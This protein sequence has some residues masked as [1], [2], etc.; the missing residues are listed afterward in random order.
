VNVIMGINQFAKMCGHFYDGTNGSGYN[1]KHPE[2]EEMQDDI[3]W[4]H[5]WACPFRC[6]P[7]NN[8]FKNCTRCLC[9]TCANEVNWRGGSKHTKIDCWN[10][11]AECTIDD[12][13]DAKCYTCRCPDYFEDPLIL[14]S[15]EAR[16]RKISYERKQRDK[17]IAI[18]RR[19]SFHI[20]KHERGLT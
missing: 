13:R 10:C 17:P 14:E 1:C 3:G 4:C 18:E 20:V 16:R 2:C 12:Q 5:S 7:D 11:C 15:R 8:D 6:A 9:E 19:K